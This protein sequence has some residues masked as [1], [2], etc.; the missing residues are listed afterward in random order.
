MPFLAKMLA[1]KIFYNFFVLPLLAQ[2]HPNIKM[3]IIFSFME[4]IENVLQKF[5]LKQYLQRDEK[6][7]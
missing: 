5:F 7:C 1:R 6:R 2:W 4:S 3:S